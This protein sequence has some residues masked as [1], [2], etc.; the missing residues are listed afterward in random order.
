MKNCSKRI[1]R[2]SVS[3]ALFVFLL[4]IFIGFSGTA[5]FAAIYTVENTN[6]TGLNSLREAI[7]AANDNDEVDEITFDVTGII[8]LS[9][10]LQI[11]SGMTIQGPGAEN[12]AVSGNDTCRVFYINTTDSVDI[13]GI[14]IVSGKLGSLS[15]HGAGVRNS[16]HNLVMTDCIFR[17]NETGDDG[18]GIYNDT[19][20]SLTLINC[21]FD[22]NSA[23][24]GGGM[25]NNQ[26]SADI[27]NCTFERNS[28]GNAGGGIYN[29]SSSPTIT[30]CRFFSNDG[31]SYGGGMYNSGSDP[32]L[33]SCDFTYNS[34]INGGGMVLHYDSNPIL[35]ECNFIDNVASSS[36]G[37]IWIRNFI[38]HN[39]TPVFSGCTFSGN[40]APKGGGI[41]SYLSSPEVNNSTFSLNSADY[42]AGMYNNGSSPDISSCTFDENVAGVSG[43]G[44]YN[45]QSELSLINSTF[46]GNTASNYGGGMCNGEVDAS[47]SA[48]VTNCTFSGNIAGNGGAM[49][50]VWSNTTVT[51][52]IFWDNSE[53]DIENGTTD[54]TLSYCIIQSDG[55]VGYPGISSNDIITADPV[56]DPLEDNGGPTQTCALGEGS[57][58]I[59]TGT[60]DGAPDKDQ[61]GAPRPDVISFD[62]GAYESGVGFY[63]I[64]ATWSDGG[65][66]SPREA[67]TLA[68]IEE[69]VFYLHPDEGYEIEEVQVDDVPV[70][71]DAVNNTYTFEPVSQSHDIYAS[72]VLTEDDD[73]DDG[74]GG[75]NIS[76][77]SAIGFLLLMPLMFLS[78]KRK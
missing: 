63:T 38:G 22:D 27:T 36:G 12:L 19:D 24:N 70:S 72:F 16:S 2:H 26:C 55:V 17:G 69:E 32:V 23:F 52:C 45:R 8:T 11:S 56:L 28:S 14:S 3:F 13:S 37:A 73:D 53:N 43:G 74:S 40:I 10:Q 4:A 39:S 77:I 9:S 41:H 50:N 49:Y 66:I 75:C 44:M 59:D 68:G 33:T 6:D 29:I 25:Y 64:T 7:E 54:L 20:S 65:S 48:D 18:G 46:I 35:T 31:A 67:H 1:F 78:G 62:I 21:I 42:G 15:A 47:V 60:S 76:A 57:S 61:R 5:G 34:A 58:A 51:N 71:Y 30:N